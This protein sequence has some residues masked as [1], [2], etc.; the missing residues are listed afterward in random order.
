MSYRLSFRW[1]FCGHTLAV[2][3][4]CAVHIISQADFIWNL[5]AV[6]PHECCILDAVCRLLYTDMVDWVC[7]LIAVSCIGSC[8]CQMCAC[9]MVKY[10]GR[11]L[12][13]HDGSARHFCSTTSTR[14]P[15]VHLSQSAAHTLRWT[16]P[17][18]SDYH[19]VIKPVYV[20]AGSNEQPHHAM[21]TYN[22]LEGCDRTTHVEIKSYSLSRQV[23]SP[24]CICVRKR[25]LAC[26]WTPPL[27]HCCLWPG[28]VV[29]VSIYFG[30]SARCGLLT[31]EKQHVL[32]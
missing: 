12:H 11:L 16:P 10:T 24:V 5:L 2:Y 18:Y 27:H 13:P 30:P 4:I 20:L 1:R 7:K 31:K 22:Q 29:P 3:Y 15:D 28:K 32:T 17:L 19:L 6:R 26:L 21:S 14:H 23:S 9:Y 25:Q 8:N